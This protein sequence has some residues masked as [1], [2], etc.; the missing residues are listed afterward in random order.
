MHNS[1]AS[2]PPLL[3]L[4]EGPSERPANIHQKVSIGAAAAGATAAGDQ[5]LFVL[6][7]VVLR[8]RGGLC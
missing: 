2:Q 8:G 5:G 6:T 1:A 4:L 7:S 3:L